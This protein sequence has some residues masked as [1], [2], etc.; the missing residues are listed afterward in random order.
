M[1]KRILSLALA[2]CLCLSLFTVPASASETL[3]QMPDVF[4]GDGVYV[5][6][7][8]LPIPEGWTVYGGVPR[9]IHEGF[10]TVFRTEDI[11]NE[12]GFYTGGKRYLVN[13]VDENGNLFDF[14]DWENPPTLYSYNPNDHINYNFHDGLCYFYDEEKETFG[15][16]DTEGNRVIESSQ[17]GL[18]FYNGLAL[19]NY[20]TFVDKSGKPV[21]SLDELGW[22]GTIMGEYSD[23]LFAYRG[24]LDA[25]RDTYFAG[26][27]NL[28]GEP[29]ITLYSGDWLDYNRNE[30]LDFGTSTFSEGY[31]FVE[32]N[33]G[34]KSHPDYILIDTE[35][36]EILTLE[37]EAPVYISGIFGGEDYSMTSAPGK[38]KGGR[39]WVNYVNTTPGIDYTEKSQDVLMDVEGNELFRY[40]RPAELT[41]G[42]TFDNGVAVSRTPSI[43]GLVID[44]NK[45]AVIPRF[46]TEGVNGGNFNVTIGFNEDNQTLGILSGAN[47][48]TY[49]ILEAHDGTY[50]GPGLVYDAAT[51]TIRQGG[52][53][54]QPTDPEPTPDPEPSADQPSS[55]AAEQVSAAIAAGL[56][57]EALQTGYTNTATRAQFCALAVELYETVTGSEIAE[58]AEFTDTT[59]VNVQKMAGIGV[60]NG[61]GNRQFNPSGQLT[62]EQAATI[63]VRLADAM[64]H[65]LPEGTASFADNA[66]I[67]S[68]A[69]DA[70]GRA[71]A[72]GLMG[73][74]GNN[75]FSPQGAYT[76]EQSIMTAFRLYETVQ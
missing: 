53:T 70:V 42:G 74:I 7:K 75:Q 64:G 35:G 52:G 41:V 27:L 39:F 20:N 11:Q 15:Y 76:V 38:V 1:K 49:Y 24:Y 58:R 2:S 23:G 25:D 50:T 57:P 26:W 17:Y 4:Q 59:D 68:W 71:Q 66:S 5:T 46:Y 51:G 43:D 62:R 36:N 9:G 34:G 8:E 31:A 16:I 45:N 18:D 63:L 40:S 44:I 3:D 37:P 6:A 56:V 22:D 61:V 60:I 48:D 54:T 19:V 12:D 33:R 65:P 21:F 10:V 67:A 73:G 47:G 72:G 28:E 32:D 69:L 13:W 55:W 29:V 14:S 30:D